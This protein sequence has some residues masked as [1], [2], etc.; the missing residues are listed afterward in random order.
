MWG[1]VSRISALVGTPF[2][3]VGTRS[4]EKVMRNFFLVPRNLVLSRVLLRRFVR[5]AVRLRRSLRRWRHIEIP[6]GV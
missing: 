1:R 4:L 5:R 2:G 3:C 6:L